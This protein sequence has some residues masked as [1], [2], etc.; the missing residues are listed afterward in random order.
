MTTPWS[1]EAHMVIV[2]MGD[3][4]VDLVRVNLMLSLDPGPV[5]EFRPFLEFDLD[6][7]HA[8]ELLGMLTIA[9][10]S[11]REAKDAVA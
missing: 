11:I 8:T 1:T 3:D 9:L 7:A 10:R 2:P 5:R 6:E 4:M